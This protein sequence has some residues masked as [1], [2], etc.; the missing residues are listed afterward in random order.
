VSSDE[1]PVEIMEDS[2]LSN[3]LDSNTLAALEDAE[4]QVSEALGID[5]TRFAKVDAVAE[6]KAEI[7]VAL[8]DLK[9]GLT[10]AGVR[11]D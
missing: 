5:L 2:I 4:A 11:L 6:M 7:T 3:E 10:R 1:E 9:F 8:S